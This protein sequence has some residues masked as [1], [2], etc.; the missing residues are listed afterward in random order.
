[1][2]HASVDNTSRIHAHITSIIFNFPVF[3]TNRSVIIIKFSSLFILEVGSEN[4][5]SLRSDVEASAFEVDVE[6]DV[7]VD[8]E[9]FF[10]GFDLPG[11]AG[12]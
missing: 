4:P 3:E 5:E 9:G 1:M 12:L 7:D 2:T 8:V 10:A 6:V 11:L